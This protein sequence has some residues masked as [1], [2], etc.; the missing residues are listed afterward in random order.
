MSA[1]SVTG[2]RVKFWSAVLIFK[3]HH[4]QLSNLPKAK[5]TVLVHITFDACDQWI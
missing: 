4:K 1:T 2:G 3:K 5:V